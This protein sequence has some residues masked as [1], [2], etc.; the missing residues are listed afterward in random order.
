MQTPGG[1]L[2]NAEQTKDDAEIIGDPTQTDKDD[3]TLIAVAAIAGFELRKLAGGGW[4][5]QRWNLR[6][7]L[8]DTDAVCSFLSA[9]GV[10]T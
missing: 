8:R 5:V 7:E 3:N 10:R 1:N 6:R 2:A 9:A 4:L